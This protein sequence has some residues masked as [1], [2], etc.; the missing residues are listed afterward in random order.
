[1][2]IEYL[3]L[4]SLPGA[5]E[6]FIFQSPP[7]EGDIYSRVRSLVKIMKTSIDDD[8]KSRS[9]SINKASD[10]YKA[11]VIVAKIK[12]I[13]SGKEGAEP[14]FKSEYQTEDRQL[15]EILGELFPREEYKKYM[16]ALELHVRYRVV[17]GDEPQFMTWC[18]VDEIKDEEFF[19]VFK[20]GD[21][22]IEV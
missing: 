11:A 20:F 13:Q 10:E 21:E 7:T 2:E 8:Q 17:L 12:Y 6:L 19:P 1:M 4:S 16:E 22:Y 9:A 14:L 3:K 15:E 5:K 18:L